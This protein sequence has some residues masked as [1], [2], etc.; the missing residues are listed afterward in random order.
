[1]NARRGLYPDQLTREGLR[2]ANCS[3]LVC[4][5]P[6]D[7]DERVRYLGNTLVQMM[8][9]MQVDDQLRM[10]VG[11]LCQALSYM[12]N[13]S[14]WRDGKLHDFDRDELKR[15]LGRFARKPEAV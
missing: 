5:L 15:K 10:T 8:T 4:V 11:Q 2:E 9:R 3:E 14:S 6:K 12:L 1:M 7:F 13:S